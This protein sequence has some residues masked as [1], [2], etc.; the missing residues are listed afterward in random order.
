[1]KIG[2]ALT[3]VELRS[4]TDR[5]LLVLLKTELKRALLLANVAA[6]RE[7][8]LYVAAERAYHSATKLLPTVSDPSRNR[9][10]L[11][12]TTLKELRVALDSLPTHRI[13][14]ACSSAVGCI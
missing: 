14:V 7:S 9:R 11:L 8:P 5:E 3:L 12:E 4:K 13:H 10:A 2:A 6:T 1:M